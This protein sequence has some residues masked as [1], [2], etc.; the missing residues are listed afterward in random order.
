MAESYYDILWISKDA[1][2][3][4][5]K[6]AYRKK[7][8]DLHPDRHAWDKQKE[9][10]FKKV[11][12]AYSV[13]SDASKKTNYDRFGT[14]DWM[15]WFQ[16][17]WFNADFDIWDIFESFFWWWFSSSRWPKKRS[18]RWEDLEMN[19][20]L[21][22]SEAIFW[23]KR[24]IKFDKQTL[25]EECEWTWAKKWTSPKQ[26]PVC[27]GKWYVKQRTQSF[28]WVMEQTVPC[29]TCSASGEVVDEPCTA[30]FWKKRISKRIEKEIDIPAWIDDGMT[31]KMRGEWNEWP[32][33]QNWD[34]Y[35]TFKV[36]SSYEWLQRDWDNLIYKILVDPIEAVLWSKRKEKIPLLWERVIE[37]KPWTQFW[38]ILRF[39]WD[40]V[41]SI[42]KDSKWDLFIHI[43]IRIPTSLSKKEREL[44]ELL[45]K[46]KEIDHA[47]HKWIFSKIFS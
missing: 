9:A 10:E 29:S 11:N 46:E 12:E 47:D 40:W 21:E 15:W 27:H 2:P 18:E 13:L 38:D 5:I 35:I 33:W 22:F 26:C 37:I 44:Y 45:A 25:C 23:A 42:S 34:F 31:I 20:K 32:W 28:F 6:K 41:K 17:S 8:M 30:C 43:E 4:E 19:L 16:S 3:D 39:K 14:A 24:T 36:P 7:A 1:S